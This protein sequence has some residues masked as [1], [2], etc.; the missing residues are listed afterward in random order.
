MKFT[1][2][3]LI[4]KE[5]KDQVIYLEH[6]TRYFF[7]GQ[8]VK[9]KVVL[10]IACGTG[11]GSHHLL[12]K[13]ASQVVG[14]DISQEAI[15]YARRKYQ[16][17]KLEF[18]QRDVMDIPSPNDYFDVVVSFETIEHI[19]NQEGFLKEAKRVLKKDGLLIISSPNALVVPPGNIFHVKELAPK[20]FNNLLSSHFKFKEFFYQDNVTS[21]YI[22]SERLINKDDHHEIKLQDFKLSASSA[23]QNLFWIGFASDGNLPQVTE[24]VV[25]FSK[26]DLEQTQLN[27]LERLR[28]EMHK[29]INSPSFRIASLLH[30]VRMKTPILKRIKR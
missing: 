30:R 1:G 5:N 10:D 4:P 26:K 11:Y 27:E 9:N 18:I 8:F 14:L 2:E 19:Q 17:D 23:D 29:I 6:M 3:R 22:L 24:L 7:A 25:L 13:G 12:E 16:N 15:E 20:E 28:K 21:S